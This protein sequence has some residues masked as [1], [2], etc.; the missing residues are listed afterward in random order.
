[1]PA[2]DDTSRGQDF[3]VATPCRIA[4]CVCGRSMALAARD[5]RRAGTCAGPVRRP[6]NPKLKG[7]RRAPSS[8]GSSVKPKRRCWQPY[9][10]NGL[11]RG[12]DLGERVGPDAS[13]RRHLSQDG[14]LTTGSGFAY[15]AGYRDRSLA[16]GRGLFDVWAGASLKRYWAVSARAEYPLNRD[17][18]VTLAGYANRY[19]YPAEEFFGIGPDSDRGDRSDL[20]AHRHPHRH[21]A[22]LSTGPA[23]FASEAASSTSGRRC[24]AAR[25]T[26]CLTSAISSPTSPRRR[27][28][29]SA[30]FSAARSSPSSTT[31]S[32]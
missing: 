32:R 1:M 13:A 14:S 15:G 10:P 28:R 18:T 27:W 16:R 9:E 17:D 29:A 11:E 3:P 22:R 30:T 31:A 6:P 20:P 5:V 24:T 2:P 7:R 25:T 8:C 19:D 12:M 26:R 21:G 4:V 23:R